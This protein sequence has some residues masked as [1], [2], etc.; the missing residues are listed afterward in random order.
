M[1]RK[2]RM[3]APSLKSF[4]TS[5]RK[6]PAKLRKNLKPPK[7]DPHPAIIN[8]L[9]NAGAFRQALIA[10]DLPIA[11]SLY[12]P[13]V[14]KTLV[15]NDY[16]MLLS[17]IHNMVMNPKTTPI[18]LSKCKADFYNVCK[19]IDSKWLYLPQNISYLLINMYSTFGNIDK[20]CKVFEN[21]KVYSS[22][23]NK[24]I[25][26]ETYKAILR[27]YSKNSMIVQ[28]ELLFKELLEVEDIALDLETFY[29]LIEAYSSVNNPIGAFKIFDY[30]VNETKLVANMGI[31]HSLLRAASKIKNPAPGQ[32]PVE[33]FQLMKEFVGQPNE[34]F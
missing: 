7:F 4:A 22:T 19:D 15:L 34:V 21:L 2:F 30:L 31:F 6:P 13:D 27:V 8:P 32:S 23:K 5:S 14:L 11:L 25:E 16:L 28:T 9:V 20:A 33:L 26:L 1:N 12:R 10:N 24:P 29:L 18:Q 17:L 3:L